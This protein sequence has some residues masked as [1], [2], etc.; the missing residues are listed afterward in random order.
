MVASGL[1][2]SDE[3]M[4]LVKNQRADGRV[5]WSPPGGVVEILDG[6]SIC[7]GLTREVHE[8]SGIAVH[9]WDGPLWVVDAVAPDMGWHLTVEVHR[10]LSY[11]GALETGDD[12][13]GI[14]TEAQ[15]VHLASVGEFLQTAWRPT[16]EPLTAWLDERW[17]VERSYSYRVE[18]T[19]PR[20]LVITR[21]DVPD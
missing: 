21:L 20:D 6:E 19:S 14:V 15:F 11:E 4:L 7:D 17:T 10:A 9:S 2:E 12:P 3:R 5:D 13:D 8:E 16:R 1:I 18:G